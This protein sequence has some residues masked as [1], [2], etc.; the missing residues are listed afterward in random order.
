MPKIITI[1]GKA[2]HGKDTFASSLEENLNMNG[3]I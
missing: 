1:S 2:R 3:Y